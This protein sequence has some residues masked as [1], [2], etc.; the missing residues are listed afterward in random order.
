MTDKDIGELW[1]D[2]YNPDHYYYDNR[3]QVMALICK[4]VEEAAEHTQSSIIA[5]G[6]GT[7]RKYY[8]RGGKREINP[9]YGWVQ[10]NFI[11]HALVRFGIDLATWEEK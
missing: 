5:G 10:R 7:S 1:A 3:G 6:G 9:Y 8:Y 11:R 4:L 2:Y